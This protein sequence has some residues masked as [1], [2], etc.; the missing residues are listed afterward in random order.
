MPSYRFEVCNFIKI[1]PVKLT[2]LQHP[3]RHFLLKKVKKNTAR[4]RL[5]M[6]NTQKQRLKELLTAK[7]KREG[8]NIE[9]NCIII[10]V[11]KFGYWH[12]KPKLRGKDVNM[13]V[14]RNIHT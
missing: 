10:K 11:S 4:G 12:T 1:E 5:N 7:K 6:C 3:P 8:L 2:V 9:K 14:L 13:N